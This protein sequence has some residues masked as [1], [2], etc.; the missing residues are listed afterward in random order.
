[1]VVSCFTVASSVGGSAVEYTGTELTAEVTAESKDAQNITLTCTKEK[2]KFWVT[3]RGMR[4]RFYR[5]EHN[6]HVEIGSSLK[7]HWMHTLSLG[8]YEASKSGTYY[9][10]IEILFRSRYKVEDVSRPL[11]L[12]YKGMLDSLNGIVIIC[13]HVNF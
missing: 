1:L 2:A 6:G 10:E 12:K 3:L 4:A 8:K 7:P 13:H 11:V 5:K 9:C